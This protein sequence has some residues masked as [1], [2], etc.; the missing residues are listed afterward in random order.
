MEWR[1]LN[2]LVES[3]VYFYSTGEHL[4]FS[5]PHQIIGTIIWCKEFPNLVGKTKNFYVHK[6]K[7]IT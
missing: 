4:D 1:S 3:R 5:I 2:N 6:S 7:K